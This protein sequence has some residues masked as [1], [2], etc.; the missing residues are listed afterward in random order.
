MSVVKFVLPFLLW[1][2]LQRDF[3]L[4]VIPLNLDTNTIYGVAKFYFNNL[5]TGTIPLWDPFVSLGRPFYAIA[6]CSLFNPVTQLVP[7]FKILG[8]NYH[9]AYTFY[10][11]VYFFIAC[12]GFYFLAKRVLKSGTAAYLA[13]IALIF[14]SLGPSMF[15]QFTLL[16]ILAPTIWFFVFLLAFA[17]EQKRGHFLGLSFSVMMVLASY[18]PFYFLTAFC[19]FV[20]FCA[21][22]YSK[23]TLAFIKNTV[24]FIIVRWGLTLI[25][26]L[27]ILAAASPLLAYKILDSSGDVV[28]PGRHCQ[29]TSAQECY[30]RTMNEKG[31]MQYEEIA[32]S[33]GLG[34]RVDTGYLFS[35]LD[36]ITYGS[37]S[38]FFVPVWIYLILVLSVF[39]RLERLTVLLAGMMVLIGLISLGNSAGLHK[40]LYE[41]V[42]FF[43]YFRNIFF[44]G[45]FLIPLSILLAIRQWQ[46]L[47]AIAPKD[48]SAKK[49]LIVAII[50]GHALFYVFLQR[51]PGV[52]A[53]SFA[54][55]ILSAMV[56]STYY[57][58][59]VRWLQRVWMWVF[60]SLI[61]IQPVC[62]MS[63]YSKNAQEFK[64][65]LPSMHVQP[66]FAWVRPDKPATSACRI[67]QF[68]HY[69][70]FWYDMN[71]T[72]APAKVGFPQ[73]APRWTF[74]LAQHTPEDTLAAYAKY[75]VY[76]YDDLDHAPVAMQGPSASLDVTHFDV[77]R[78]VFKTHFDKRKLLVYNDSFT[79]SWKAFID[80]SKTELLRVNG[81]F[82]GV[83]VPPGEHRVEFRY[84]PPGGQWVYPLA[85]AA[86]MLFLI[87]TM[88]ELKRDA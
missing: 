40:F 15:T 61:I 70:D 63:A 87:W 42:F 20:V 35:H 16:E 56:F 71:M 69:E 48:F 46:A 2:F 80:G 66:S 83:W 52:M 84:S 8:L 81:A 19:V 32:R 75:K 79:T 77:N 29:Y 49:L 58:W 53:V 39:L 23:E 22:L 36:K 28:A 60:A 38:L 59:G 24:S 26:V 86:L 64:C 5:L 55:V 47:L 65:V 1:I 4:G 12:L 14:S 11:A 72:D 50:A 82:K 57:V 44:L 45:V 33:G 88:V 68:A 41:Q 43:K 62:M 73:S 37:D 67:Y 54:T 21:V 85:L 3:L 17:H 51:Y 6:I 10:L 31:G 13:Y 7:L 76:V 78:T 30:D 74:D 34:E 18:L 25:C 27:G 9:L